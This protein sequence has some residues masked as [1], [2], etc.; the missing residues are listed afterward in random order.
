[1]TPPDTNYNE[2]AWAIDLIAHIKQIAA[3][4]NRPVKDAG[5]ERTIGAEGGSLFPDVLLFGDRETARILQGWELK[6]PDTPI[7]DY[8]YR[9]NAEAKAD[10]LGLDSFLLWNVSIARLYARNS[11]EDGFSIAKE[12]L[13]LAD[14]RTR[15]SVL[16]N[17]S[18]WEDLADEIIGYVND[19]FDT[20]SLEGRQFIDAYRSGGITSLMLQNYGLVADALAHAAARDH[21]LRSKMA[22]W[23]ARYRAEYTGQTP[24]RA[25]GQAVI[26]NWIGKLLFAHILGA[27]D[28]RAKR[29]IVFD[30]NT[31]PGQ[32]LEA[33]QRLSQ[34]CDFWTIFSDSFG[35]RE[36]PAESWKQLQQFN[37]LLGDLR[38]GSVDQQQLADILKATVEVARRKVRGQYATPDPLARLLVNLCLRDSVGDRVLDP[39]CGS[40]TIARVALEAKMRNGV[41]SSEEAAASVWAGDQDPQAVQI[42]TLGLAD[43]SLMHTLL[44]VFREDAFS[45]APSK[46]IT[47]RSS[48]DGS[49]LSEKLGCFDAIISNLPFVAQDGRQHYMT[50]IRRVNDGLGR[51]Y[52]LSGRADVA[53]YL[54]FALHPLLKEG[55]RLGI[56]ITNAWLGTDWGAA[57][58]NALL[59][60]YDLRCV[61]TSGAGRWFQDSEVVTNILIAEKAKN[62]EQVDQ[63][64]AF[65]VLKRPIDEMEE[66]DARLAAAQIELRRP[67]TETMSIRTVSL[68]NLTRCRK[69]GMDG[70]AQ[71]VECDWIHELPL[72]RVNGLFVIRRGERRGMNALFYPK[73]EHGIEGEYIRPLLK[74]PNDLKTLRA[75]AVRE[76][77]TCSQ[78]E[79]EL[80]AMGH[81]GALAW[82]GRFKSEEN[83][84]KLDRSHLRW[85]EMDASEVSDL[86]MFINLG[87]R[88]FVGYLDPPAFVDQ[89]MVRLDGKRGVDV[90]LCHALLNSAIGLFMIE[91]LG[92]GRGLGAL[93]LN[94]NRIEKCMHML[95]PGG[96]G[97]EERRNIMQAFDPVLQREVLGV[98]DELEQED[99]RRFDDTVMDAF[100]LGVSRS[101]VYEALLELF[102]I[103]LCARQ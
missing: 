64:I 16:P 96:L 57:F 28:E 83:M 11:S 90:P 10:A 21:I 76:A 79:Q 29:A 73:G 98:A 84:R 51:Q 60:Y 87:E 74:S 86:V 99:R 69:L 59:Q 35:L 20:G 55:G 47:F 30:E 18:R 17:R 91:G 2:P 37:Q 103:R 45:L 54:P 102:G 8:P 1:M 44:R 23:W 63:D 68:A 38:V 101:T 89:R 46:A 5:G 80:A 52:K 70:S 85:Y 14:I 25:L 53:A 3:R 97:E 13:D 4:T 66:N 71:F 33:F 94:K 42:A 75:G 41:V 9:Q 24:E 22:L 93:D 27:I 77:F 6:M 31:T 61:I 49:V 43:P 15:S 12:W 95:D 19:L 48:T 40:G 100:G 81:T 62:R 36:V 88:L 82:I 67:Q 58:L 78:S 34:E 26:T 50:A 72:V 39:C 92:F 7:D 56:I 32:A 65:V